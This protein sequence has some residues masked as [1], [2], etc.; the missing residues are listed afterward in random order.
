MLSSDL[1]PS[2]SQTLDFTLSPPAG[3]PSAKFC[4][5]VIRREVLKR[6]REERWDLVSPY[7]SLSLPVLL[8]H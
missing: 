2:P 1:P 8:P 5:A 4:F 6:V 3:S 7:F